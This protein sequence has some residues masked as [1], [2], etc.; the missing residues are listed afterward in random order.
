MKKLTLT[1]LTGMLAMGAFAQTTATT[2]QTDKTQGMKDVRK[3]TRDIRHDKGIRHYE[4]K[5]GDKAEAKAETRDIKADKK[6][7]AADAKNLKK[8]G[9]KHPVKRADKQIHRENER[10]EKH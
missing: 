6:D 5:H 8:D 9:I 1:V 4:M 3:D 2:A 10:H 7:R